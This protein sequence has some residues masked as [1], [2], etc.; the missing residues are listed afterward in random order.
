M[1]MI[2]KIFQD[3]LSQKAAHL[4]FIENYLKKYPESRGQ[5]TPCFWG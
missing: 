4:S 1:D 5:T 3:P 2:L